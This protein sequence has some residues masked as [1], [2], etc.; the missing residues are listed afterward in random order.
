M[1]ASVHHR[2]KVI[3]IVGAFLLVADYIVTASIS[4]LSG[5]Q[6]VGVPHPGIFAGVAILGIG[7]LNF[8]GPKRTGEL[9]VAISVPTVITVVVLAF[10]SLP[11]LGEAWHNLKPLSGGFWHGWSGFVAIVLAVSGVEPIANAVSKN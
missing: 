10:F 8:F 1:Y 3:A 11:H 9:A 6:Y 5:F 7:A 2:S 4:V